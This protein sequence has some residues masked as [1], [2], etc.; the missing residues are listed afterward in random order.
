[1]PPGTTV[2]MW[3]AEAGYLVALEIKSDTGGLD[4]QVTNVNDPANVVETP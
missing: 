1:M 2:D 4:L 3:A